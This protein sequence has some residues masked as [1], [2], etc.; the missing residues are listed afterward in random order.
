[1]I[2]LVRRQVDRIAFVAMRMA[3]L[4]G[5]GVTRLLAALPRS[6]SRRLGGDLAVFPYVPPDYPGYSV[7]IGNHLRFLETAGVAYRVFAAATANDLYSLDQWPRW[8]RYLFYVKVYWRRLAQVLQAR[9]FRR[10][11]V[12]RGLFPYYPDQRTPH[13]ERLLRRLVPNSVI[14]FYDADYVTS[15]LIV[16]A[17]VHYFDRVTVVGTHIKKHFVAIHRDVQVFPLCIELE[18]YPRKQDYSAGRPLRVLWMGSAANATRLTTVSGALREF[19]RLHS[20]RVVMVCRRPIEISDV[21]VECVAWSDRVTHDLLPYCDIAIYP[22]EDSE[23][24]RGKMALKVLEYMA[25]GLPVV[26][27]PFG[28]APCVVH[29]ETA[30]VAEGHT[31]W[32][33]ALNALAE[34]QDLRERIGRNA[35]IAIEKYHTTEVVFPQFRRLVIEAN[36][37]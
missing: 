19:S 26:A 29:G 20:V 37:A 5:I 9:T 18:E 21:D 25:V 3:L 7:R 10:A 27:S 36:G 13:L 2:R 33:A 24:D 16:D 35:R 31:R 12:Q 8:A 23:V 4:L 28:L 11:F 14:D 6:P 1:M 30:L 15:P 17:S 22:A 34:S 32:L